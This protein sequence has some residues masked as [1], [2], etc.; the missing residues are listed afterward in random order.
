MLSGTS[1]I[2][3]NKKVTLFQFLGSDGQPDAA[4]SSAR[5]SDSGILSHELK[6]QLESLQ[7]EL[8]KSESGREEAQVKAEM[9]E[10]QLEDAKAKEAETQVFFFSFRQALKAIIL[11]QIRFVHS[12]LVSAKEREIESQSVWI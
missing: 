11:S 12:T 9:F 6:R 4:A 3:N 10:R 2:V 7:D 8:F 1:D 5:G